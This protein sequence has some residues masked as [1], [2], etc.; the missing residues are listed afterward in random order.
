M[1]NLNIKRPTLTLNMCVYRVF[2]MVLLELYI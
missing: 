2:M 1:E